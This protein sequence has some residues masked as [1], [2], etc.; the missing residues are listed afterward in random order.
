[1]SDRGDHLT[2]ISYFPGCSLESSARESNVSLIEAAGIWAS[3]LSN[4]RTGIA[5][6]LLP[7]TSWIRRSPFPWRYGTCLW[8]LGP[9]PHGHVPP[10]P[11]PTAGS[12]SAFERGAGDPTGPGT[13]LWPGRLPGS[14]HHPLFGGAGAPG[15]GAPQAGPGAGP[16]RPE[17]RAVL[18]L[19]LIPAPGVAQGHLLPGGV[20]QCPDPAGGRRLDTRAL[21]LPVLRQFLERCPGRRRHPLGERDFGQRRRRGGGVPGDLLRHVPAQPGNPLHLGAPPAHLSLFRNF[22][23]GPG[24]RRITRAGSRV[25]WWTPGLF[26]KPGS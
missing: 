7:S 10:L 11:L 2:D 15:T 16:E 1:M 23:P 3:T 19:H 14:E 24:R 22:G 13:P 4:W 25:T 5:V 21:M 18:R 8:P 6:A 17:V 12:P 20:G 9:P 26:S